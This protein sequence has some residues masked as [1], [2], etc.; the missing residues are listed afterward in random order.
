MGRRC[1][2]PIKKTCPKCGTEHI[3]RRAVYCSRSCANSRKY[4]EKQK[5]DKSIAKREAIMADTDEAEEE[6]LRILRN[7][8]IPPTIPHPD[9]GLQQGQFVDGDELW[10]HVDPDAGDEDSW[11]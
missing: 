9:E 2:P 8:R 3:K 5:L 10:T 6:R 4:T 7:K 11:G 1:K